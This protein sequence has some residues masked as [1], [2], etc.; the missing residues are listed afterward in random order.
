MK[1]K[2]SRRNQA[3]SDVHQQLHKLPYL[4]HEN[5]VIATDI[6]GGKT[7]RLIKGGITA[8]LSMAQLRHEICS[9]VDRGTFPDRLERLARFLEE[10]TPN[11]T[12]QV[13]EE[14]DPEVVV[15]DLIDTIQVIACNLPEQVL[16]DLVYSC[17]ENPEGVFDGDYDEFDSTVQNLGFSYETDDEDQDSLIAPSPKLLKQIVTQMNRAEFYHSFI[18]L[19]GLGLDRNQFPPPPSQFLAGYEFLE[20]LIEFLTRRSYPQEDIGMLT[21]ANES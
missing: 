9:G 14:K 5:L 20:Q 17:I 4:E 7:T 15:S 18:Y 8:R 19:A 3:L 1:R 12:E 11:N 10:C 16:F 13:V 6:I 2:K 21:S